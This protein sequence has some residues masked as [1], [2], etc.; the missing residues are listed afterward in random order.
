MLLR[1]TPPSGVCLPG[2]PS[3]ALFLTLYEG[4]DSTD[5]KC[6]SVT[7]GFGM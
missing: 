5:A 6:K 2:F 1:A 4:A 3:T 7:V